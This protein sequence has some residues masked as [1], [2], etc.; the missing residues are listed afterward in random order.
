MLPNVP[1][2]L[3][4]IYCR[5][6]LLPKTFYEGE[7]GSEAYDIYVDHTEK[8]KTIRKYMEEHK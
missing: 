8:I 3:I 5:E 4:Y 1:R 2:N 7:R 6:T